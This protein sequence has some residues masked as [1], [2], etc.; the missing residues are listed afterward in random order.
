MVFMTLM[1]CFFFTCFTVSLLALYI[2]FK[3]SHILWDNIDCEKTTNKME[4]ILI[5]SCD[6]GIGLKL[7]KYA[8]K[9]TR[10]TVIC[11]F[12]R[13]TSGGFKKLARLQ[14]RWSSRL[15]LVK[16]DVTSVDDIESIKKM[17]NDLQDSGQIKSLVALINNA[18]T[19]VYGEFDWLTWNQ[20]QSQIEVNLLGTLRLT[21]AFVPNIIQS[22]GRIINISSVNDSAV[23][24]GL[25]VYSATKSA[26]STFSRG[27]GYELGKFGANVITMRLGDFARLTNI[28][29]THEGCCDDM[30]NEMDSSKRDV[31]GDYFQEFNH[32]I[33]KNY[34]MTSPK[35]FS[36]SKLFQDF[37]R[38]LLAKRP[39]NIITCTPLTFRVFY[40][41]IEIL[42]IQLQ[43]RLLDLLFQYVFKW[44][45]Q[46]FVGSANSRGSAGITGEC[47][48]NNL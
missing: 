7:A 12:L 6:S 18:G 2:V 38:A 3:N 11:G 29:A 30:W 26:L 14:S 36:D 13:T 8:I 31:Y 27:L 32:H 10:Y 21:R 23:F 34:G 40:I 45:K 17:V 41:I 47:H 9:K 35:G 39:P 20:I 1:C 46:Q 48:N 19:L 4:A 15:I 42:P 16:L 22:R 24:P 44:N 43:Y 37:R 28:M 25:S 33:L 5:S